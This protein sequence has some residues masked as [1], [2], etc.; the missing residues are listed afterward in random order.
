MSAE[1]I[2]LP[3]GR[4]AATAQP[5]FALGYELSNER[6]RNRSLIVARPAVPVLMDEV[7]II[8]RTK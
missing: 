5:L 8:R 1:I 4:L 2:L 7:R 3:R 6:R